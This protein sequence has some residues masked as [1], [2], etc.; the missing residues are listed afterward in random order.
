MSRYLY[1]GIGRMVAGLLVPLASSPSF[2]PV[3]W[4]EEG[5]GRVVVGVPRRRRGS[6]GPTDIAAVCTTHRHTTG[7]VAAETVR[8]RALDYVVT[9]KKER[10]FS[11]LE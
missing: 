5:G 6:C 8:A 9:P 7:G 4:E 10:A 1:G 3:T 2:P 11:S